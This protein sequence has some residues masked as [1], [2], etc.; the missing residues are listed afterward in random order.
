MP[1]EDKVRLAVFGSF[2]R[3]REVLREALQGR[4]AQF[5]RVVGVATDDPAKSYVSPGKRVWQ[6]PHEFW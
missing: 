4:L 5:V 6:Y 2:Y 3:G 1:L